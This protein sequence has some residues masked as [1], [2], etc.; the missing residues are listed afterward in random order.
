MAGLWSLG[1][2]G[3]PVIKPDGSSIAEWEKSFSK[4]NPLYNPSYEFWGR[5]EYKLFHEGR[6]GVVAAGDTLFSSE[7]F[8][9]SRDAQGNYKSHIE[10]IGNAASALKARNTKLFI[11]VIP[12]KA[13][14]FGILPPSKKSVLSDFAASM[15]ERKIPVINL[16]R[17]LGKK[18]FFRQ[19][20]H[21]TPEGARASAKIIARIVKS[22]CP[23]CMGMETYKNR[24]E[25]KGNFKGDLTRYVPGVDFVDEQI[26]SFSLE[27]E[28]SANLFGDEDVPVV[29]VGTSYSAKREFNFVNFLKEYLGSDVLN[30]A[31]EGLGPFATMKAYLGGGPPP[32]KI[33]IWEIPERYLTLP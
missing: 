26:D 15:G 22:A 3:P 13:R 12:A 30:M 20:T 4:A 16:G 14:I 6:T 27:R 25:V 11:A 24:I 19:D 17:A 5:A 29:L 1:G 2:A 28:K 7:E 21:W 23:G 33:V 32:A 8:S 10:F 31:D 9:G 18:G